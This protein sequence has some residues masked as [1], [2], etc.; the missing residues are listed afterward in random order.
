MNS[1][2]LWGAGDTAKP[3]G[4]AAGRLITDDAWLDGLW[5]LHR[6]QAE[7]LD[8]TPRLLSEPSGDLRIALATGFDTTEDLARWDQAVLAPVRAALECGRLHQVTLQ[9]DVARVHV[10]A[11]AR[12]A[13]W[14]RPLPLHESLA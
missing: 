5:R 6:G 14:R 12:W 11:V 2:W 7:S 13:Y 4:S 3:L 8:D 10:P 1:V 9:F